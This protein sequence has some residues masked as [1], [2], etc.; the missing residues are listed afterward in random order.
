MENQ[1]GGIF[2]YGARNRDALPLA[3]AQALAAFSDQ[4]IVALRKL[5]DEIVGQR[6][7]GGLDDAGGVH[8]REA[9]ADIVPDRVVKED[10]FLGDHGNL[11]A[12]G[13]Q[14][15]VADVHSINPDGSARYFVKARKQVNQGRLPRPAG[16]DDGNHFAFSRREVDAAQHKCR[17]VG[18]ADAVELDFA[19]ERRKR[20]RSR[21][22]LLLFRQVEQS[23]NLLRGAFRLLELLIDG[24]HSL[25]GLVGL[26]QRVDKGEKQS[27]GYLVQANFVARV[28]QQKGDHDGLEQIHERSEEHTSELQSRPHLVCRLL[29]EKKKE[30]A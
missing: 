18:E 25:Y 12:Q 16:S 27:K 29:L 9:V 2:Q 22:V 11:R 28:E 21:G 17:I 4:R 10:V 24:A 13:T 3:A 1:D 19:G 20:A 6:G 23:K 15:H 30:C 5:Q 26:E 7:A 8:I 14:C